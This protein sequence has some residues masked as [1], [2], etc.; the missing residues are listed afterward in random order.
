MLVR[1]VRTI[2]YIVTNPNRSLLWKII[3]SLFLVFLFVLVVVTMIGTLFGDS[4]LS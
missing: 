4:S 1:L 2:R 3:D